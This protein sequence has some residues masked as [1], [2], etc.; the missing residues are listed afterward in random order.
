MKN[1]AA[2]FLQIRKDCS[3]VLPNFSTHPLTSFH[4]ILFF[5]PVLTGRVF[6]N[7]INAFQNV[8]HILISFIHIFIRLH[9]FLF[10]R[11]G[12]VYWPMTENITEEQNA[13]M[14][15]VLEPAEEN[16]SSSAEAKGKSGED[17]PEDPLVQKEKELEAVREELS[18]EKDRFLR[19][20]AEF[21]NYKKRNAR[22]M[23]DFRKFANESLIRELLP[24][25]DNLERAVQSAEGNAEADKSIREGVGLIH[26]DI[27]RVF[28]K[29]SVKTVQS[30][31]FPFDP[32]FHEAIGQ[33][34]S[35][36][37]DNIVV[38][39]FQKGYLLHDR[40]IRPAMVIVSRAKAKE[41]AADADNDVKENREIPEESDNETP[42][43]QNESSQGDTE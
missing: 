35:E 19:F 17:S 12:R 36:Q 29:F 38:K 16:A 22:E 4:I 41:A 40:L 37:G 6:Q 18:A 32:A 25:I 28:E 21:D 3:F 10:K 14:A 2:Y 23:Q 30:L 34:E 33:E 15:E 26:R 31:G 43:A 5:I 24:V 11:R 42:D 13:G 27:L 9:Q 20:Y 39:E 7:F 8:W 1:S